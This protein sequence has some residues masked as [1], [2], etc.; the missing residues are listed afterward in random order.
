MK[1]VGI[2]IK[3]KQTE[4]SD[5]IAFNKRDKLLCNDIL[6]LLYRDKSGYPIKTLLWERTV[7]RNALF[8]SAFGLLILPFTTL[9][10]PLPMPMPPLLFH[11]IFRC[12]WTFNVF[13]HMLQ[14]NVN[15]MHMRWR[16]TG[17]TFLNMKEIVVSYKLCFIMEF[18]CIFFGLCI[19][20]VNV[21][22]CCSGAWAANVF[23]RISIKIKFIARRIIRL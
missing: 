19:V 13:I 1:S 16:G 10:F 6:D 4:L 12:F 11:F 7:I 8:S 2:L 15:D 17:G 23:I 22:V 14:S 9:E 20:A 18:Y 3:I 21:V 5:S